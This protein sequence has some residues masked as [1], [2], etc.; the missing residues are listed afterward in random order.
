MSLDITNIPAIMRSK[1][2]NIGAALMDSWFSRN[3]NIAPRYGLPDATT[4]RMAWVLSF[5]RAPDV[6]QK[7]MGDRIWQNEPARKEIASMLR[8][9]G[10]LMRNA[11]FTRSFGD[12]SLPVRRQDEDFINQRVLGMSADLDDLNAALANFVFN[13]LVAGCVRSE[14]KSGG[15][16]VEISEI[17]VYVKDSYDFNGDQFLGYWDDSDNSVSMVNPF[18]GTAVHN[19]DFRDWRSKNHK[20]GDFRVF[21]DIKRTKISPP[22]VFRFK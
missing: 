15:Y 3:I 7:L 10:Y 11:C 22:D 12:L 6:Y 18:S 16:E 21:S 4:I 17:G 13:V 19:R 14:D 1:K 8:R 5:K 20:G 9:K 2:W